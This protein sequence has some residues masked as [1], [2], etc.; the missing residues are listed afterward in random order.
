M[1]C[2]NGSSMGSKLGQLQVSDNRRYL[3]YED[4]TPFFYL[5]DTA[6]ELL[7]RLDREEAD[8]YLEDRAEKGFTVVQTVAISP[9]SGLEDPNANGEYVLHDD[10]PSR[11]NEQYFEHVDYIVD[12]AA[13]LGLFVGMLPTWGNYWRNAEPD[14]DPIFN[15]ENARMYGEFLGDRYR[16]SPILWLMGGD[17]PI[18]TEDER[19]VIEAMVEGIKAGDDGTHLMTYHPV[20][21]G[22][23]STDFHDAEWLDFNMFQSSHG[24]YDHDNGFFS[25]RDYALEPTKPTLDGEP[26]YEGIPVGFYFEDSSSLDRFGAYDVRQAAY[27]SLLAGACGH[28]YGDN[29][30]MQM[31]RP[32]FEPGIEANIHWEDALDHPGARQ[33][34]FVRRLYESRPFRKLEPA[35][36]ILVDAPDSG[37]AKVRAALAND[38]SFAFIYSPR[39]ERFTV[40]NAVID[41]EIREIWYDPRYGSAH[42]THSTGNEG[43]QTY[44]PPSSGKG[45]DWVL[46]LE[47]ASEAFPLPDHERNRNTNTAPDE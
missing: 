17:Q 9:A 38:G 30:V 19:A 22:Q 32:E 5:G 40:D 45:N 26:R 10:D 8:T 29:N 4:G 18:Q 24:G 23:S 12:R 39:G 34:G 37:G 28:T 44:T 14:H 21:P 16:N 15:V 35:Q 46:I 31:W 1:L 11:P 20:G 36:E 25:E 47:A 43:F 33:M 42:Y 27:W 2:Y 7:H 3:E 13:E 41:G 6:W